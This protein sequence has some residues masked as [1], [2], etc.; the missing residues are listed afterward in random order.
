M[1]IYVKA[2][3]KK[4]YNKLQLFF[5]C[6]KDL[7]TFTHTLT[8]II[9]KICIFKA[10]CMSGTSNTKPTISLNKKK[11]NVEKITHTFKP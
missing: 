5:L 10:K 1:K 4:K 9:Q 6:V 11:E 2:T 8:T 7:Y 3:Y